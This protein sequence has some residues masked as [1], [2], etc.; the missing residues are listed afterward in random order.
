MWAEQ[1][2]PYH[3]GKAASKLLDISVGLDSVQVPKIWTIGQ[4]SIRAG[5]GTTRKS[6]LV[7]AQDPELPKDLIP[8]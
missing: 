5:S 6:E 3:I 1:M 4:K 7:P 8:F 2:F